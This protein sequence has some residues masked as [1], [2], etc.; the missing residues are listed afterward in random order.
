[1]GALNVHTETL[2]GE[3]ITINSTDNVVRLSIVGASGSVLVNGSQS[4]QGRPS[5]AV[6]FSSG[7]GITLTSPS[8]NN[9]IDGVT[10]DATSGS[11]DLVI[12][13]Q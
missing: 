2:S 11:C 6:T 12:S 1:M 13:T 10:I 8:I 3:S 7:E 4:F 9:P 5:T